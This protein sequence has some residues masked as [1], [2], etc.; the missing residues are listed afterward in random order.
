MQKITLP[1]RIFE[2]DLFLFKKN[3]TRSNSEFYEMWHYA[4]D[5]HWSLCLLV[6]LRWILT[7]YCWIIFQ[8][9]RTSNWSMYGLQG[10]T[11]KSALLDD[12]LTAALDVWIF[13]LKSFLQHIFSCL[14][15]FCDW[16]G[17][18]YTP[19]DLKNNKLSVRGLPSFSAIAIAKIQHFL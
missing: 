18:F 17:G 3:I 4:H 10:E 5:K 11:R 12:C 16:P 7:W 19:Y 8:N 14:V 6:I 1:V 9:P 13:V 2:I 15:S